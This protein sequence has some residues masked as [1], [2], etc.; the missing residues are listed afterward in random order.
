[1][2]VVLIPMGRDAPEDVLAYI[3]S[4]KYRLHVLEHLAEQGTARPG[5]IADSTGDPRPHVSRALTELREKGVVQLQVPESRN[6]GR[7]YALTEVGETAWPKIRTK[8]R[9]IT[10][11]IEKLSDPETRAVV[12]A[13]K[14]ECGQE[15]RIVSVFDESEVTIL[16]ARPDVLSS[17]SDEEFE[18]GLRTLIFD[19]SLDDLNMPDE[20]CWSEVTHFSEYSLLRVRTGEDV[21]IGVS[22]DR[23]RDV[24]VPA[25]AESLVSAFESDPSE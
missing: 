25:F 5:E 14:E 7:Y 17:Y 15:L 4:S 12:E 13:A 22:F 11:S 20:E 21:Q 18:Q 19:H 1:M 8:T 10:W 3:L 2:F 9:R 24:L 23:S 16:H 6:V